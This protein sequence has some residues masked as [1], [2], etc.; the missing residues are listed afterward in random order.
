MASWLTCALCGVVQ[1]V[2]VDEP[3]PRDWKPTADGEGV[4]CPECTKNE[5]LRKV[6][7][8]ISQTLKQ[9]DLES[10]LDHVVP[11]EVQSDD[12]LDVE[13]IPPPDDFEDSFEECEV[14]KGPCQGH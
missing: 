1:E 4:W 14:C 11:P 12:L 9:L 5:G 2:A 6:G 8:D 3:M 13:V 10:A 7:H